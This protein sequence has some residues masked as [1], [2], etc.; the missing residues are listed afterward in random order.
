MKNKTFLKQIGWILLVLG[1]AGYLLSGSW[2]PSLYFSSGENLAH[3]VLGVILLAAGYWGQSA[4]LT[5]WL[6]ILVGVLGLYFAAYGW[7]VNSNY[8]NLGSLE[9][10][11]NII[12]LIVGVWALWVVWGKKK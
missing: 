1:I 9:G 10:I 7:F 11:D 12:H 6:V 4:A 2:A 5:K 8:Y 3:V